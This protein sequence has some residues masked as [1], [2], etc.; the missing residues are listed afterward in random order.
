MFNWLYSGI[1][2]NRIKTLILLATIPAK[3][4][5]KHNRVISLAPVITF[6]YTFDC[7]A[8]QERI[9]KFYSYSGIDGIGSIECIQKKAKLIHNLDREVILAIFSLLFIMLWDILSNGV[10]LTREI[11]TISPFKLFYFFLSP[12]FY[13]T[14]TVRICFTEFSYS[15][16][17]DTR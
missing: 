10:R 7:S 1:G 2:I 12:P 17:L 8:N 5:E 4:E 14:V 9:L 3:L 6:N 13:L 16:I 11:R 15:N